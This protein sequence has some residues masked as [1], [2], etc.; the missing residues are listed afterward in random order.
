MEYLFK[1]INYISRVGIISIN[2]Y[3]LL[4]VLTVALTI[5]VNESNNHLFSSGESNGF[6]TIR[7]LLKGSL[8]L[9]DLVWKSID[10]IQNLENIAS[11]KAWGVE[12]PIWAC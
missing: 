12:F 1:F 3:S 7:T 5:E 9:S 6:Q 2:L 8:A 10:H 11:M 4:S